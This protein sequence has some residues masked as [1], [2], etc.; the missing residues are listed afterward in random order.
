MTVHP[1]RPR[2]PQRLEVFAV[3]DT[4]AQITWARLGPGRV[5]F[6]IDGRRHAVEANGGPGAV[7][8]DD[9]K[10]ETDYEVLLHGAGARHGGSRLGLRTLPDPPGRELFRFA[11]ISDLHLG[12]DRFGLFGLVREDPGAVTPHPVMCA[13]AAIDEALAWGAELLIVKGDVTTESFP[14]HWE[15]AGELLAGLPIPVEVLPGN[16]DRGRKRTVEPQ[17]ALARHGLRLVHGV[18]ALELPGARLVLFDS[19]VP[20]WGYGR[21]N[22]LVD[23]VV[24]VASRTDKPV[25]VATHHYPQPL[26]VPH[27]WPPG[28]PSFAANRFIRALAEAN[29]A[30]FITSGHTHRNRLRH[31]LG[32]PISEVGSPKDYPGVWGGYVLYE[33]ALRQVVRRV[34]A[35]EAIAW[36]EYTRRAVAGAWGLWAPGRLEQR[37]FVHT[38]PSSAPGGGRARSGHE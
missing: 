7:T 26:P 36:T 10:P 13:R 33:D 38:W 24:R 3:E 12:A 35:P 22:H 2:R 30:S 32:I 4:A 18:Q 8:L 9:L 28:V 17:P 19:T 14:E 27:F 6:E 15:A 16:H 20:D 5:E 29:P 1:T 21:Y 23:D 11:T 34:A 37:C 25:F 31:K